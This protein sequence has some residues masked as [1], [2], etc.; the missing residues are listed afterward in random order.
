MARLHFPDFDFVP[1]FA[2]RND[3]LRALDLYDEHDRIE[4]DDA[5]INIV[6]PIRNLVERPEER[7]AP[8]G[9]LYSEYVAR[10]A[11]PNIPCREN[12]RQD[13]APLGAP[14]QA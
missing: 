10:G 9:A 2:L 6:I 7:G 1:S 12:A 13:R 3:E 14:Y 11:F 8:C 4:G 5:G